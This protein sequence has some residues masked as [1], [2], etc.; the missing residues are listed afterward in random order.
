MAEQLQYHSMAEFEKHHHQGKSESTYFP[1][2]E[3]HLCVS[4][5]ESHICPRP[6]QRPPLNQKGDVPEYTGGLLP[7]SVT[8]GDGGRGEGKVTFSFPKKEPVPSS[9]I[10]HH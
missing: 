4:K 3:A 8:G 2:Q 5:W 10:P 7:S 9:H 6:L 1:P